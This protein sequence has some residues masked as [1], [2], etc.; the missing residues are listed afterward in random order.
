MT[1]AII[2]A[3]TIELTLETLTTRITDN[4]APASRRIYQHTFRE[5]RR[6]AEAR[7]I[8]DLELT[9][10]AVNDFVNAANV[11]KSTRQN[12]L[13][14]IRKVLEILAIANP[15]FA[16]HFTLVKALVKIKPQAGD[17]KRKRHS[18]RSLSRAELLQF[19]SIWSDDKSNVGIR[20]NALVRLDVYTG[21]RRSE[22]VSLRW[23]DIDS[24]SQTIKVRHGKGDK[25][26]IVAIAD[27][28]MGTV[29][30]LKA[31]RQA[32]G[33]GYEFVF[34]RMTRGKGSRFGIDKPANPQTAYSVVTRT[35]QLADIGHA[36]PHDLRRT[37]I[38]TALDHGA[39]LADMQA[40]AGHATPATTLLYAQARDAKA[41]RERIRF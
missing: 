33:G 3:P 15:D 14:H 32:Q 39:S 17:A 29:R 28:T 9:F 25:E 35:A 10:D 26:R 31:L 19:L 21:L 2:A 4:L 27:I 7:G 8:G 36:S 12:R 23:D 22:L 24:D 18:K 38:T 16:P 30:S 13:S 20:N 37:H 41:R 40:Q 6:F 34:P 1:R 11:G 5:W